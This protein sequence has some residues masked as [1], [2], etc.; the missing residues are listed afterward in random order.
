MFRVTI[1]SVE[2]WAQDGRL[3]SIRTPVGRYRFRETVVREHLR[4]AQS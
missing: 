4:T 1:G 2:H 3:A